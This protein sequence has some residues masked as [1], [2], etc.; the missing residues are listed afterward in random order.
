[1]L[2]LKLQY[3]GHLMQTAD[4]LK[5]A[6]MLEK[7]ERKRRRV[8]QRM[9]WSGSIIIQ[10]KIWANSGSLWRAKEP[11]MLPSM[12]SQS[13]TQ[14]SSWT[15][16]KERPQSLF[17]TQYWKW[18]SKNFAMFYLLEER[19]QL[20]REERIRQGCGYQEAGFIESHFRGCLLPMNSGIEWTF[21][22]KSV[23]IKK[24]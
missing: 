5:Y 20:T 16:T 21:Y 18:H 1:M 9:R 17:V 15:T 24:S 7:I 23:P 12:G 13:G 10:W 8:W 6:L 14:L 22:F 3:F 11:G 2:K 19:H 4:S